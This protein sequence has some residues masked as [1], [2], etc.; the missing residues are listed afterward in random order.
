[1]PESGN[2]PPERPP[3][4][5][6]WKIPRPWPDVP[7]DS[8]ERVGHA[9]EKQCMQARMP[10]YSGFIPS[11]RSR[12]VFMRT[13]SA[14]AG[15]AALEQVN[16]RQQDRGAAGAASGPELSHRSAS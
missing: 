15:A 13:P 11:V 7:A 8:T 2:L 12:N 6:R 14:L 16:I 5:Y 9:V 10:G 4:D 3:V 1:M